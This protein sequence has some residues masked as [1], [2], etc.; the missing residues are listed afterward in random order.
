MDFAPSMNCADPSISDI[1]SFDSGR[2][3]KSGRDRR[4]RSDATR[5]KRC[6]A[7]SDADALTVVRAAYTNP[8]D[9]RRTRRATRHAHRNGTAHSRSDAFWSCSRGSHC[10]TERRR[11]VC[12][13]SPL[14]PSLGRSHRTNAPQRCATARSISDDLAARPAE[15]AWPTL[16]VRKLSA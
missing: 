8:V 5:S 4:A 9:R 14:R 2:L 10:L 3:R 12:S 6:R 7:P 16:T 13:R 11:H 15:R 1:W